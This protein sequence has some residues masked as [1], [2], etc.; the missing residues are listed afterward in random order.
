MDAIFSRDLFSRDLFSR[1]YVHANMMGPNA[2]LLAEEVCASLA[3]KPG[4]RVL[5]LGCGTG[6]TSMYLASQFGVEVVAMDLWIAAADNA[7]RFEEKGMSQQI[8]PLNMDVADLPHQKPFP[9]NSFDALLNI[10]SYH[11]FGASSSFFDSHLAPV[12]KPGGRVAI[13]VPGLKTPFNQGVPPELA[14]FWQAEI[15]FFTVDWWR[16]LWQQSA[17]LQIDMCT[18]SECC[19][20]AWL[21]WLACDNPYAIRDRDMMKAENGRWFNFTKMTGSINK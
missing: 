21:E 12:I 3:L 13:V 15:N 19:E 4:M 20:Q 1:E 10:D 8:T 14:P 5:D 18:E 17:F 7:Q 6:L 11:Y 9:E 2:L 16:Q